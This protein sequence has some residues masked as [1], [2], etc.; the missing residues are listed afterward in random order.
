V[1]RA[2]FTSGLQLT[3]IIGAVVM[4]GLAIMTVVLL[5]DVS[6]HT[7]PESQPQL[8]PLAQ[9]QPIADSR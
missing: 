8:E 1:A 2:A 7:E 3:A 9:P 6:I 4:T 5:R